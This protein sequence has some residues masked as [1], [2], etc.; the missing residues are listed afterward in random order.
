MLRSLRTLVYC[1]LVLLPTGRAAAQAPDCTS[2][3]SGVAAL[4]PLV[5]LST[6]YRVGCLGGSRDT[7]PLTVAATRSLPEQFPDGA[8]KRELRLAL[9]SVLNPV[10]EATRRER[11]L[12]AADP[13]AQELVEALDSVV[14][15]VQRAAIAELS[16]DEL[17]ELDALRWSWDPSINAFGGIDIPIASAI[18]ASCATPSQPAC[19][20]VVRSASFVLRATHLVERGLAFHGRPFLLDALNASSRRDARWT[21]YFESTVTQ[22]PWELM[23]NGKL[24]GRTLQRQQGFAE[25]PTSQWIIAHPVAGLEYEPRATADARLNPAV[26]IE[27]LG[28]NRWRWSDENAPVRAW[29]ASGV[30][31]Y[32]DQGGTDAV[33]LGVLLRVAHQYSVT[34][35]LRDGRPGWMLS[36]KLGEWVSGRRD[37]IETAMRLG[38]TRNAE[39]ASR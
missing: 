24:F 38:S 11:S 31:T 37:A 6:L 22:F 19:E 33:K 27:V 10:L 16:G 39:L 17:R 21:A 5:Q 12:H 20:R 23:L 1:F 15:R 7:D 28:I 26:G 25:P 36:A 29:G 30:A 32:V 34:V 9:L 13:T 2:V 4:E 18:S 35:T 14:H 8:S 3:A